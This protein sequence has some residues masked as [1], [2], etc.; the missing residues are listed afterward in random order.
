MLND[1]GNAGVRMAQLEKKKK[2]NKHKLSQ[3]WF[4][5]Q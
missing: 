4:A 2:G 3:V 1:N 5:G